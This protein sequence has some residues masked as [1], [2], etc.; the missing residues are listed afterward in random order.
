MT[1]SHC[2]VK[3]AECCYHVYER[4]QMTYTS[5]EYCAITCYRLSRGSR[6]VIFSARR[7][8]IRHSCRVAALLTLVLLFRSDRESRPS[9]TA[10]L[11]RSSGARPN[12]AAAENYTPPADRHTLPTPNQW[13]IRT[14]LLQSHCSESCLRIAPYGE[15]VVHF[16]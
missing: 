15:N 6:K 13:T 7:H 11:S 2:R 5:V 16:R 12:G 14:V 8:R 10:T 9:L 1:V 3:T 4:K